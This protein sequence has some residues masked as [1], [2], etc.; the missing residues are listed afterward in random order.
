[1]NGF[2][3]NLITRLEYRQI[4][5]LDEVI[6]W[7]IKISKT[8]EAEKFKGRQHFQRITQNPLPRADAQVN[9]RPPENI[10]TKQILTNSPRQPIRPWIK[11]LIPGQPGLNSPAICRYCKFPGHDISACRK[12]VYRNAQQ[13]CAG[14]AKSRPV[15][16][17][18]AKET[19]QTM[20]R[21]I[22]TEPTIMEPTT[23]TG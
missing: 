2:P 21:P 18:A 20:V 4:S 16:S 23:S 13:N 1:M 22:N 8:L 17:G 3:S 5:T 14:K 9:M 15:A 10:P 6:E 19:A 12:L 11:P 7:A